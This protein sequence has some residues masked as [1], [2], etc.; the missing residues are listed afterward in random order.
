MSS[1]NRLNGEPYLHYLHDERLSHWKLSQK[2]NFQ[3]RQDSELGKIMYIDY[4]HDP[5]F[6]DWTH[7]EKE[8]FSRE[9]FLRLKAEHVDVSKDPRFTTMSGHEKYYIK[10]NIKKNRKQCVIC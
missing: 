1:E 4:L 2:K 6:Q 8:E 5:F 7:D 10:A 3:K 9:Q